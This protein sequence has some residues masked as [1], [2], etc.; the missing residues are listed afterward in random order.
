[1]PQTTANVPLWAENVANAQADT[2]PRVGDANR[3]AEH[4]HREQQRRAERR[5]DE[6][7]ALR[8]RI[9]GNQ[10]PGTAEARAVQ[11]RGRAEQARGGLAEI[12]ALPV[13]E[14]ARVV[15][16]R[17]ARVEAERAAADRT[18]AARDAR[19]AQLHQFQSPSSDHERRGPER[20][21]IGM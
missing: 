15:R 6:R 2:D 13:T 1:M 4:T 21:G 5:A 9:F 7:A 18:Q 20:D 17:T 10:P 8:G 3:D 12:E 19:A 16:D 11:W 14:A